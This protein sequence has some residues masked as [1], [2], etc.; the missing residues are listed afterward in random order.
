MQDIPP[1]IPSLH[2]PFNQNLKT[3]RWVCLYIKSRKSNIKSSVLNIDFYLFMLRL[4]RNEYKKTG[5]TNIVG[6]PS[7]QATFEVSAYLSIFN[8]QNQYDKIQEIVQKERTEGL[9]MQIYSTYKAASYFVNM[10]KDKLGL[11]DGRNQLTSDGSELLSIKAG[12]F[13]FSTKEKEFF[14]ERILAKDFLLFVSLCLFKRLNHIHKV[15]DEAN[16]QYYFLDK[17]YQI[18]DFNFKNS[19]LGNFNTVRSFWIDSLDVLDKR[20]MIR[21]KYMGLILNNKTTV[22]WFTE[23][24]SRFQSFES[25]HFNSY[26]TYL[27]NKKKIEN[28]YTF[29]ANNGQSDLGFVNLYDVK[30]DFRIS[31]EKFEELINRYY[32]SEKGKKNIF[33]TNIVN[34]IDRR[35]RFFV[36]GIPVLKIKIKETHEY[37]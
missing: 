35:K 11:I 21:P 34:S 6:L 4:L 36:R 37:K 25:D 19:S 2:R 26:K 32:E 12:L 31:S 13:T 5:Q 30:E 33:F 8:K 29:L 27:K 1:F 23:L 22:D 17:Y 24:R 15:K 28:R 9:E 20:M 3:A 7:S 16:L 10:A 18:R 14:Y